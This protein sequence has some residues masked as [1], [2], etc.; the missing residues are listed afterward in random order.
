MKIEIVGNNFLI[1][2]NLEI[3]DNLI[4][5]NFNIQKDNKQIIQELLTRVEILKMFLNKLL[6]EDKT[7]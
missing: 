2:G 3:I 6:E 1:N 4:L 7:N 5:N